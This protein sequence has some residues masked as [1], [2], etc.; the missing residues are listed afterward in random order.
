M[1]GKVHV[2][3]TIDYLKTGILTVHK[4]FKLRTK[5]LL[6]PQKYE[7]YKCK[8]GVRGRVVC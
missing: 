8:Y 1:L 7:L 6:S 3:S 2:I 4:N 5:H